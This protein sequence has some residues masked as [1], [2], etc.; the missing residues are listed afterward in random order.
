MKKL[1]TVMAMMMCV[2]LL[3]GASSCHGPQYEEY[4][5]TD[6]ENKGRD[7]MQAWLDEHMDG[8]KVTSAEV[9]IS[10]IPSGPQYLTD[11]VFG[12]FTCGGETRSY[13]IET[14]ENIVYLTC[15]S[16]LLNDRLESYIFETL[17]LEGREDECRLT[18]VD[19]GF[20]S[21]FSG[22]GGGDIADNYLEMEYLPGELVLALEEAGYT[23]SDDEKGSK[24]S[25]EEL[26]E[27]D[28]D[29]SETEE[30]EDT[31]DE[32]SDDEEQGSKI[33]WSDEAV[34]IMDDFIRDTENRPE[35]TLSGNLWLP[36]D[37]DLKSYDMAFFE[38][39]R[40][41]AGLHYTLFYLYQD[42]VT[43]SA[44][45]W[46][47]TYERQEVSPIEDFYIEYTAEYF[48]EECR[49]G[50][51]KERERYEH[52]ADDLEVKKTG[53]GYSFICNNPD[54]WFTFHIYADDNSEIR[55]HEYLDRYDQA[56]HGD[57]YG[58][59]RYIERNVVWEQTDDGLWRL[60]REDTGE[61]MLLSDAD[62]LVFRD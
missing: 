26:S 15:D 44:I 29:V 56:A 31:D 52:D 32:D 6:M 17:D 41:S 38:G 24:K 7:M 30:D 2:L 60:V 21:G 12:E 43:V 47:T 35:I 51:I 19:A 50:E 37:I 5:V 33:I 49:N 48:S 25:F 18:D 14:D 57:K 10:Y 46:Y 45:G 61:H 23:I 54:I 3:S 27:E 42:N 53:E 20:L 16:D 39:L 13:E 22:Y 1:T 28:E 4:E 34:E 40:K 58:G 9:Y 55:E 11:S 8:A 59:G 36:E 62:Q